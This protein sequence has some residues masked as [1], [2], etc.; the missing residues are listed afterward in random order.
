M[1]TR[2]WST[3]KME[4]YSEERMASTFWYIPVYPAEDSMFPIKVTTANPKVR[5]MHACMQKWKE[6]NEA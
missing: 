2:F 6:K 4:H 1:V 3:K 5:V